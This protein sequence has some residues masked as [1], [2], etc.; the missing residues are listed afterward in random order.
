[1]DTTEITNPENEL[2]KAI[3]NT[4]KSGDGKSVFAWILDQCGFFETDPNKVKPELIALANRIMVTGHMT[5][6]G[7]MGKYAMAVIESYDSSDLKR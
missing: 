1:M 2:A 3:Y 4:F 6:T 5:V 7:D